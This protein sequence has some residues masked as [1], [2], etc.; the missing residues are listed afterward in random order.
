MI[1]LPI[2]LGVSPWALRGIDKFGTVILGVLWVVFLVASEWCFHRL[3]KHELSVIDVANVLGAEV[4][5]LG[6][7]Y[8]G[9]LL[10]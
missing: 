1:D 3:L 2:V 7:V 4:L 9:H 6:T 10:I 8:G 5:L